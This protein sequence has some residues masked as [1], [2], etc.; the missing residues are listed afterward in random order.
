MFDCV[1]SKYVLLFLLQLVP[2]PDISSYPSPDW[3]PQ[4]RCDSD[5]ESDDTDCEA[6]SACIVTFGPTAHAILSMLIGL[7]LVLRWGSGGVL[8]GVWRGSG[9]GLEGVDADIKPLLSHSTTG[10][11]N[12]RAQLFADATPQLGLHADVKPLLSHPTTG[13]FNS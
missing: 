12:S 8:E 2:A 4:V 7:L 11:F 10:E 9:G 1:A 6:V 3:S 13:E 5:S